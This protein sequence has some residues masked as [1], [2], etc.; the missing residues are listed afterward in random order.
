MGSSSVRGVWRRI[1]ALVAAATFLSTT[2]LT[3]SACSRDPEAAQ[4][5]A[6]AAIGIETS[7]L[8]FTIVNQSGRA[9]LDLELAIVSAGGTPFT[10][11]VS[12]LEIG[13][14]RDFSL[15]DFSSRDGTRFNLRVVRP[16]TARVK[17][18]DSFG[19][20]YA[21]EAPWR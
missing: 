11:L 12:R 20:E 9:L 4:A 21:V 8:A 13:E 15:N 6:D 2:V 18:K 5:T 1:L 16:R 10:H 3:V 7:S 17:A 14:K 19:K